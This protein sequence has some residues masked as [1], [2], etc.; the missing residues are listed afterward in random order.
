MS[1]TTYLTTSMMPQVV[2]IHVKLAMIVHMHE[3]MCKCILHMLL[4]P[5]MTLAEDYCTCGMESAGTGGVAWGTDDAGGRDGA[6]RQT[7]VVEHEYDFWACS[8]Y[9]DHYGIYVVQE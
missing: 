7:E 4:A 5:E 3:F 9:G 2:P 6:A 1:Q 8:R